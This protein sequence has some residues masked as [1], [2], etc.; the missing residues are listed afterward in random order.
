MV[1]T[2]ELKKIIA[3]NGLSQKRVADLIG[4]TPKAFYEKM[5]SGLFKSDEIQIM[6]ELLE[7]ENPTEIFFA[8]NVT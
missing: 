5:K 1:R 4:I 2:E 3:K 6:I 8:E 7:I